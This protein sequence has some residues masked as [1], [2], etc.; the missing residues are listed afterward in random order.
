MAANLAP[1]ALE[2]QQRYII[3]IGDGASG[4]RMA[5]HHH[6]EPLTVA[7]SILRLSL[8][9]RIAVVSLLI[10]LI[11]ATVYWTIG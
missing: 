4:S 11:W 6:S 3:T 10:V 5:N 8:W 9:Q 1:A 2:N 7:P